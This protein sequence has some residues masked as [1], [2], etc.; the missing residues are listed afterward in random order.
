MFSLLNALL[1]VVLV[2]WLIYSVR[3]WHCLFQGYLIARK[4]GMPLRTLRGSDIS[5]CALYPMRESPH[6]TTRTGVRA[7]IICYI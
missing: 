3:S 4:V 2:L 7:Y 6:N 1:G 5:A